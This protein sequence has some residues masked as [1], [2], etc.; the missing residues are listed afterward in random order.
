MKRRTIL[1]TVIAS[2]LTL[3]LPGGVV[4]ASGA[5][6]QT[7]HFSL[8]NAT[9]PVTCAGAMTGVTAANATGNGVGH[10]TGNA[11][12]F[13]D[14]STFTGDG[15]ITISPP[16]TTY[17]GHIQEWDGFEGNKQN[18]VVHETFN[19]QGTNVADPTQSL[20]MHVNF[21]RTTNADGTVTAFHADVSCQ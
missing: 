13:W 16:G 21:D 17:Q 3:A 18:F 1:M 10:Q 20:N 2:A 6:T 14:T 7:V 5:F 15:T 19:F 4:K 11:N 9:V 12:G 8:F